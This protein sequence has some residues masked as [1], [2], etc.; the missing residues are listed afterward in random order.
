M[1]PTLQAID[2]TA[3]PN[4]WI[5]VVRGQICG[6]GTTAQQAHRAAKQ[7]RPKRQPQLF[8][9][10]CKGKRVIGQE[11]LASQPLLQQVTKIL[12]KQQITVYLVGGA[13]RDLLLGRTKIVDLDFAVP[14]N[15]L[16]IARRVANELGGAFFVLDA[17]R[18]TGRVICNDA[19]K[20]YLDFATFRGADLLT[21]L[22]DRDFT[23]N[24]IALNLTTTPELIDPF[25]GQVDLQQKRIQMVSATAFQND[26]LRTLRAVRQAVDFEFTIE[27]KTISALK[28]V[29]PKITT[30]SPERQR[31]ELLKI[32]KTSQPGQAIQMLQTFGALSYVLPDVSAMIGVTQSAPHHLDVFDHTT[33][34]LDIWANL[35][36]HGLPNSLSTWQTEIENYFQQTLAGGFTLQLLMRLGLLLHDVGKPLTRSDNNQRIRF[37]GHEI[38][39]A[40]IATNIM[41]SLRFSGQAIDFVEKLVTNHMRPLALTHNNTI[42]RRAIYRLFKD[43]GT[44]NFDAGPAVALHALADHRAT[45]PVG[46]GEVAEQ[47]LIKVIATL[48]QA[49]FNQ[50]KQIIHPPALLTGRD[51]IKQFNLKQGKIVGELLSHLREAQAVGD[52][53]DRDSALN[54]IASQL[55][56]M[57]EQSTS[58]AQ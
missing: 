57:D 48:L 54:F 29:T 34:A 11:W 9:I 50:Q 35:N 52:V 56:K 31:D 21:D 2:T 32:L 28:Q 26:P 55:I 13:V 7:A 27:P 25:Q 18:Q 23:I 36:Q 20:S 45:Y 41:E 30:V 22:G 15:G 42:S 6:V 17:V 16:H 43:S 1:K 10:G 5:A 33:K 8:F 37:L 51:L 58:H 19:H 39:S 40:K 46:E 44:K 38:E 47:K 3:Y 24:A 14:E 12:Q 49:Y 4:R 53:L